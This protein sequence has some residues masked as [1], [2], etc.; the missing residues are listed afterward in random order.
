MFCQLQVDRLMWLFFSWEGGH[1]GKKVREQTWAGHVV[2]SKA[3]HPLELQTS[4]TETVLYQEPLSHFPALPWLLGNLTLFHY[5]Q[6]TSEVQFTL[7]GIR[8]THKHVL[9]NKNPL[10]DI[11]SSAALLRHLGIQE[12]QIRL[13][14]AGVPHSTRQRKQLLF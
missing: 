7:G 6:L 8:W 3:Y 11:L 14:W 4:L 1:A 13:P 12:E 9:A 2:H 10:K 5:L